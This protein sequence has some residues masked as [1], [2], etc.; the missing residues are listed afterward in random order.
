MSQSMQ[1]FFFK[2]PCILKSI[3]V[4]TIIYVRRKHN[5]FNPA[6][7][8]SRQ[9]SI[10]GEDGSTFRHGNS[11]NNPVGIY[12]VLPYEPRCKSGLLRGSAP[13]KC[14]GLRVIV[15]PI[16]RRDLSARLHPCVLESAGRFSLNSRDEVGRA[17]KKRIQQM[18]DAP[19]STLSYSVAHVIPGLSL[20]CYESL[21]GLIKVGFTRPT[22]MPRLESA[23]KFAPNILPEATIKSLHGER[24]LRDDSFA[25]EIAV[26]GRSL[27]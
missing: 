6:I 11:N 7:L 19:R 1:K 18:R 23:N 26:V 13:L 5:N 22:S 17:W 25:V 14:C 15:G 20:Q 3:S 27:R 12:Y 24:T 2:I 4:D 9:H 16:A 10:V 21:I 8:N